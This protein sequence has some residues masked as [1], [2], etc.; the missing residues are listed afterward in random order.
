MKVLS[1]LFNPNQPITTTSISKIVSNSKKDLSKTITIIES[2][3]GIKKIDNL[4]EF[5]TYSAFEQSC[6]VTNWIHKSPEY[7]QREI[8]SQGLFYNIPYNI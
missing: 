6:I 8:I 7:L 5:I 3:P 4:D 2:K 1:F